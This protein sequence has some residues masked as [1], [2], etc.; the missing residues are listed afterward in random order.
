MGNNKHELEDVR[1][2]WENNPLFYGES[3]YE[4]GTKE[5]FEEHRKV[6]VDDCFA[7]D[8]DERIFPDDEHRN[9]VLDLGCGVGFWTVELGSRRCELIASA[10][11]TKKAIEITKKRCAFY[12]VKS[13]LS[14]QNAEELGF[15]DEQFSH[16]ICLGVIHHTPNPEKCVAEIAR[17]LK[18]G[19]TAVISVYY[20][21]ILLRNW[22]W[23]R[24]PFRIFSKIVK[25]RGRGREGFL[26]SRD[27]ND[28]VRMFDGAEN[29]IGIAFSDEEFSNMV[30]KYFVVE[31]TFYHFFPARALPFTLPKRIHKILDHLFP[32]MIY[33]KLRKK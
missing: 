2:F 1:Y 18:K 29:P 30:G 9:R 26:L 32:F 33:K 19:G 21:N 24:I 23:M 4:I 11:L 3:K 7:G 25:L 8:L 28:L 14:V 27:V 20:K 5:F 15:K 10:D 6:V 22:F 13:H 12:N 31:K 17:V 16:V